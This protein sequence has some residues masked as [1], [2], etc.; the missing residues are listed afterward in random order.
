MLFVCTRTTRL[1]A[2]HSFFTWKL[3]WLTRLLWLRNTSKAPA[4]EQH[5]KSR[6]RSVSIFITGSMLALHCNHLSLVLTHL[7]KLFDYTTRYFDRH[8]NV[9]HRVYYQ[10]NKKEMNRYVHVYLTNQQQI[11]IRSDSDLQN[12]IFRSR[13]EPKYHHHWQQQQMTISISSRD[14]VQ[15]CRTA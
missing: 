10:V 12:Q 7:M 11:I 9:N 8:A 4:P 1:V 14:K 2:L 3:L 6:K 13:R 15:L 5:I